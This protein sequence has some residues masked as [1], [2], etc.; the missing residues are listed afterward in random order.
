MEDAIR[1][2]EHPI[3]VE[4]QSSDPSYKMDWTLHDIYDT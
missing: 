4:G 1:D 3:T 2:L